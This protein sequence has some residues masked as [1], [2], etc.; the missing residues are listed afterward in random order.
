MA[1]LASSLQ[2]AASPDSVTLGEREQS[3]DGEVQVMPVQWT[4]WN[5]P[6]F[7]CELE[8]RMPP[9]SKK[10]CQ[11]T[12]S[13][14]SLMVALSRGES[15]NPAQEQSSNTSGRRRERLADAPR[16]VT[17]R[18]PEF[19]R[20]AAT[21]PEGPSVAAT[22]DIIFAGGGTPPPLAF[23]PFPRPRPLPLSTIPRA[24]LSAFGAWTL[25][26]APA[27]SPPAPPAF[28]KTRPRDRC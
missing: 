8:Q 7:S 23:F 18:P 17:P 11:Q 22:R 24:A 10:L 13:F 6:L 15:L 21:P 19:M 1:R 5:T 4:I 25:P 14:I 20:P 3:G 2:R 28:H 26:P 16:N 9:V 12:V 27:L